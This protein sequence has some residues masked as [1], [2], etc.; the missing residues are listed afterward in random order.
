MFLSAI[1]EQ[2]KQATKSK[3]GTHHSSRET[4]PCVSGRIVEAFELLA[5]KANECSVLSEQV[6]E[7]PEDKKPYNQYRCWRPNL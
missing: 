2:D 1:G 6:S 7:S 3:A 5:R 4:R